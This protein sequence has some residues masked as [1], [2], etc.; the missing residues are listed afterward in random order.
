MFEIFTL[1]SCQ[2]WARYNTFTV[3]D[4]HKYEQNKTGTTDTGY[5]HIKR[6]KHELASES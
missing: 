5:E 2:I 1:H 3:P 4:A 6:E